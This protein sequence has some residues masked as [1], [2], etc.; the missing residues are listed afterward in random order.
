[1]KPIVMRT[2]TRLLIH[3]YLWRKR[4]AARKDMPVAARIDCRTARMLLDIYRPSKLTV[5]SGFLVPAEL[6]HLYGAVPM[7]IEHLAAMMA[8]AGYAGRAL[9]HAE[10]AGFSRDGCSFHRAT[11]GAWLGGYLPS[12]KLV[13]ATSHLCDLQNQTLEE[14]AVRM[15]VPYVLL[16]VPQE[17]S[18]TAVEYL[19][20]QLAEIEETLVALS[21]KRAEPGDW[22]HIF[23][24][25]NETRELMIRVNE[26]R[27]RLPSPLYGR[28]AFTLAL[29]ALLLMGTPFLR[30]CYRDLVTEIR[31]SCGKEGDNGERSERYRIIWLLAYPYF[32]GNFIDRLEN[33]LGV[34]AVAEELGHVYWSPLDA[35][36]P[37]HSLAVKMLQNPN[38]GPVTNRIALIEGM[39]REYEADG[40][41]Q[42][43]QWG[44]R[45]GCGGVRP[46]A[47]ALQRLDVPF[48]DLDGDCV[49][50]RN[51]SEGQTRTRLDGFVEVMEKRRGK[52][53]RVISKDGLFLGIDIGSLSGKAVV[54]DSAGRILFRKVI[55]TGASSR[56]AAAKLKEMVFD[57]NGFERRIQTCV[58]TG[59]GRKAVD[60]AD[61]QVTEI[62]C[63][64]RGM[65]HLVRGVGTIIDIGGQ[66]T[67]AIALDGEGAVQ[68]FAMNDK[69]AAGTGRF[70]EMMTRALEI[71]IEDMGRR[72]LQAK[73]SASISS[74]CT[75]FAES[76]VISL[77]A[78]GRPV[79][80]ICRGICESIA[81]RTVSM[82]GRVGRH[83]K[84]AMSGGV[85]KNVG[86]VKALERA[87]GARLE[88]PPEPQV[89][90]AIGAALIARERL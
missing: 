39:V 57:G 19:A 40:V 8:A 14:L 63:H 69:C 90:G 62:T 77:I 86:V 75:V 11:L 82:L 66:D 45:Q 22:D 43:S 80:E 85:A 44:C 13:A 59:Y 12:F 67:K 28:E 37:H 79:E 54:I 81:V 36:R 15:G 83:G 65:A 46:I 21:G 16:D 29:E 88:I 26:L 74:L 58:A 38:L 49:D 35:S 73:R 10:S 33:E 5:L 2:L 60:F 7:F 9:G 30:D 25:S 71:D 76:E 89:V 47:D 32:E 70:L 72:A 64:A 53:G 1:M 87:L 17:H 55:L 48:L 31:K 41:L 4:W 50:S 56:R 6:L 23:S 84:I 61:E 27:R 3:G 34:H 42:F 18:P 24:L 20:G 52:S 68:R 78:E 51:Y